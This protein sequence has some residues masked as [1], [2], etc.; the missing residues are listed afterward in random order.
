MGQESS[1]GGG[2]KVMN[3]EKEKNTLD[4]VE[5]LVEL[6]NAQGYYTTVVS[7]MLV[8]GNSIAVMVMP[9]NDYDHYYDGSYRQGF[10][11]Q[12][13][14]KHTQQMLAY[15]T[16]VQAGEFLKNVGD[17]PSHNGSYKFEKMMISTDPN[18]IGKTEKQQFIWGAQF[19]AD[20]YIKNQ[21][22][23]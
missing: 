6:L 1:G 15:D 3:T 20:L 5:R 8:D 12:V 19:R 2:K 23:G 13:V 14:A 9:S 16:V 11:F 17:I 21:R 4:F 18:V 22:S 7:P 10:Q